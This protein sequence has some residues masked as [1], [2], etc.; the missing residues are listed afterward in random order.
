[1]TYDDV[2]VFEGDGGIP[3]EK[4][5]AQKSLGGEKMAQKLNGKK[6]GSQVHG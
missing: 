3:E 2:A 4:G 5:G 6:D 1:M